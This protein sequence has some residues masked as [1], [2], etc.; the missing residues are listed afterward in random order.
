MSLPGQGSACLVFRNASL[1]KV[2]L[3]S[4][5]NGLAHPRKRV[6]GTKSDGQSDA[7]EPAVGD[8]LD[9]FPKQPCI[10]A[11]NSAR[12]AIL[13]ISDFQFDG[14]IDQLPQLGLEFGRPDFRIFRLDAVDQ[15]DAEIEVDGFVAKDVLKLFADA[16]HAVLPVKGEHHHKAAVE[17]DAFHDDVKSDEVF[18][19]T[20][21]PGGRVRAEVRL[22]NVTGEFH[23]KGV[24]VPN[25]IHLVVHVENFALVQRERLTN[26]VERV[27]VNG[28]LEGLSQQILARLGIGDVLENG[29]HDVVS[30][31]AFRGAEETEV[32]HDDLAFIGGEFVGFPKLNVLLHRHLGGHP[33]I[34][35]AIE[36]MFPGPLVF[37][38]HELV[39]VHRLAVQEA[40]VLRVDAPGE[41]MSRGTFRCRIATSHGVGG[42]MIGFGME[43]HQGK[44]RPRHESRSH[45]RRI[46][47]SGRACR[48]E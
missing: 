33:M 48:T 41:I 6:F 21:H 17:E 13:G 20:P 16:G 26:V 29:E 4:E 15:V 3:L 35:A 22:K 37:E 19:K 40:F 30:H 23:F 27:G 44:N 24:L 39:D 14:L 32:A 7:F 47:E 34:G 18:N 8:V 5:V 10:Q 31:E 45:A 28:F 25:G 11:K 2:F 42:L 36:V 46:N 12:K 1:K 43:N 38:R 9:V